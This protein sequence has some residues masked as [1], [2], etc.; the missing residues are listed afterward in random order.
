MQTQAFSSDAQTTPEAA[1]AAANAMAGKAVPQGMIQKVV[2]VSVVDVGGLFV[3]T[4]IVALEPDPKAALPLQ[5]AEPA[6]EETVKEDDGK[7]E[8]GEGDAEKSSNARDSYFIPAPSQNDNAGDFPAAIPE[9]KDGAM[10]PQTP[11]VQSME[12]LPDPD[13]DLLN[14]EIPDTELGP[15]TL[16]DDAVALAE[17]MRDEFNDR[18]EDL[19][20]ISK[21]GITPEQQASNE[22]HNQKALDAEETRREA[23][24]NNAALAQEDLAPEP[25][26]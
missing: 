13:H 25:V 4:V 16:A 19:L 2:N 9:I 6:E 20:V 23:A 10:T 12:Q 8:G 11:I 1:T 5:P 21:D 14:P 3:A 15:E 22:A 24:L 26:S 18:P 7:T 17:E